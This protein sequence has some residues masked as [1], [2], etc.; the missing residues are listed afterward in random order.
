MDYDLVCLA[1]LAGGTYVTIHAIVTVK[2]CGSGPSNSRRVQAA[3]ALHDLCL[4]L[5]EE[6]ARLLLCRAEGH[7]GRRRDKSF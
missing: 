4:V 1:G 6:A 2:S 5:A 3:I 7:L